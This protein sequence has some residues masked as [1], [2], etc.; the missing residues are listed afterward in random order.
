[1]SKTYPPVPDDV[2]RGYPINWS[3]ERLRA[4]LDRTRCIDRGRATD[5]GIPAQQPPGEVFDF[6][7]LPQTSETL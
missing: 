4:N 1:M 3:A 6:D 2:L 5:F 7:R